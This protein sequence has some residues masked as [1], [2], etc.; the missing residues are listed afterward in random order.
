MYMKKP[1]AAEK[2][3]LKALKGRLTLLQADLAKQKKVEGID[4]NVTVK[5]KKSNARFVRTKIE[6]GPDKAVGTFVLDIAITA[7]T[8]TVF[9]PLSIASGKKPTGFVYQIEGT[10]ESALGSASVAT[11]VDGLTRITAGTIEYLALKKGETAILRLTV[12]TKGKVG[13]EYSVVVTRINY[14]L[15]QGDARYQQ[16]MK[17][18]ASQ[19][20]RF[21]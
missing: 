6:A 2:A 12:V 5:L 14:K 8:E 20:L 15:S 17:P 4:D 18:I 13:Q 10:A 11:T 3:E 9:V 19:T 16:Y 21:A 1:T 7:K